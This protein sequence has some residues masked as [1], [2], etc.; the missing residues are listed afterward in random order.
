[1]EEFVVENIGAC[2]EKTLLEIIQ[3]IVRD[4]DERTYT[5]DCMG[6][7]VEFSIHKRDEVF[8]LLL[9]RKTIRGDEID[10]FNAMHGDTCFILPKLGEVLIC[11]FRDL[12]DWGVD[13]AEV[14]EFLQ[15][16]SP[17]QHLLE[18]R[19]SVDNLVMRFSNNVPDA[20]DDSMKDAVEVSE[21]E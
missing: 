4:N 2:R 18:T 10:Y 14:M 11:L 15:E 17:K 12:E 16:V 8:H 9:I 6:G 7:V 21:E 5:V 3:S 13:V 19:E 20:S 1:M